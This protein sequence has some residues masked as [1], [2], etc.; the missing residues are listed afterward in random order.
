MSA[1]QLQQ[2]LKVDG[3]DSRRYYHPPIH[4][5]QAYEGR[6]ARPRPL[7]VTDDLAASVLSP[8]LWSHMTEDTVV[9]VAGTIK[10]LHEHADVVVDALRSTP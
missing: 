1:P 3:I 7:P 9:R 6:W 8:P 5:Q 10:N 4:E 2:A